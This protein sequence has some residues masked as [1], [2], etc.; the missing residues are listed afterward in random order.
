[1]GERFDSGVMEAAANSAFW[2]AI[3][4]F[5]AQQSRLVC[6]RIPVV[7]IVQDL[8]AAGSVPGDALGVLIRRSD[9]N[10]QILRMTW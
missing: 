9:L 7:T 3:E 4:R 1:M 5:R 6:R 2:P 8:C 10:T